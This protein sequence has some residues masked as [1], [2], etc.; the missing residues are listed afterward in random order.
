MILTGQAAWDRMF[1]VSTIISDLVWETN[2]FYP[3]LFKFLHVHVTLG[4]N[5]LVK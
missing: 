4:A 5:A 2:L 1:G 3:R